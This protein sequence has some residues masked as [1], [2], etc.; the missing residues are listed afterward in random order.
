MIQPPVVVPPVVIHQP[1]VVV[2]PVVVPPTP[3]IAAVTQPL[4]VVG[5]YDPQIHGYVLPV[6]PC[7]FARFPFPSNATRWYSGYM[8]Q[9]RNQRDGTLYEK[10]VPPHYE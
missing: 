1:A 4:L 6:D 2:P 7:G 3:P 10:W 5:G 8:I 9:C